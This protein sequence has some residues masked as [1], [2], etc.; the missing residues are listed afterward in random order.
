M[1][2]NT[3]TYVLEKTVALDRKMVWQLL[4]DNNRMNAYVGLFPVTFSPATKQG[5]E[6]FYREAQAKLLGLVALKWQEFPFQWQKYESYIVE[7]RYLSGPLKQYSMQAELFDTTDGGTRIKLT[8]TF[9]PLNLAGYVGAL[10]NGVPAVK[11]MIVYLNDYLA[12]GAERISEAPQ[13]PNDA[14]VNLP[15]LERLSALLAKSPVDQNYVKLLHHYL[16]DRENRDVAQIEPV[17]LANHWRADV[18]ETLRVLL[19]ATKVGMLNLSWNVICPN[20]RV[21]KEEHSSLSE[22]EEQFHCDLCGVNYDADFDQFV[23]LNFSVHPAVR[24]AYAEVYCVGGPTITPHI[25][26]QQIIVSGETKS[27]KVPQNEEAFRLRVIQA[28]HQVAI[29][30]NGESHPLV[31]TDHGWSKELVSGEADIAVTNSSSADIVVALENA[32]WTTQTVT[33]AK[34]TAMQEFRDLFSSEV[35]SPGQKIS[36]GHVTILFTDLKG[37]TTLYETAGDSSAYGQVRNHFDFLADH[38]AGNSGSIVKTI[39]DAVMAIFHRPEDGLKAALAIQKNLAVFNETATEALVLRIGLYSGA[40]IAVNSNDRLDY[41]GRTVNIAARIQGQGEG[42]DIVLSKRVLAQPESAMLL[43]SAGIELEEFSAEL[44][45]IDAA[46]ELVRVRLAKGLVVEEL[47]S[48]VV[49]N[50]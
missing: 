46:V 41:F 49:S 18:D 31:Y 5:A 1:K 38:I 43:A 28:N 33:A 39:G 30:Q 7:R 23:E 36:V 25:Q 13:K 9:L 15:E 11:K 20:C 32:D 45:G 19:Y 2:F 37:S 10:A 3:K 42:G 21:S 14:K 4:A 8:A 22:L 26:A 17:Q 6:V 24:T 40:A 35:L 34:V 29:K 44:K 47:A 12:S 27:F 50:R 16:I 48:Q